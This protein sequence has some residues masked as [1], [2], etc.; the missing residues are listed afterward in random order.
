MDYRQGLREGMTVYSSDQKKLGKVAAKQEGA[1]LIE[2]GFFFPKEYSCSYGAIADIR[3]DDIFLSMTGDMLTSGYTSTQDRPSEYREGETRIPL[4][5]ERLEATKRGYQ[6]GEVKIH[7]DVTTETQQ[8]SVPLRHEEV[9]VERTAAPAREPGA[10]EATFEKGTTTIPVYEEEAEIRKRP[11]IR[12]E[13][14]VS[15]QGTVEERR[16]SEEV[17][18]ETAD[19]DKSGDLDTHRGDKP[20]NR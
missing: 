2:K 4:A 10:G 6:S 20:R 7:K 5:E 17:R 15:K 8:V 16:A 18:K 13:V 3:G 9:H 11:V 12:E 14:R 1:F 19:V